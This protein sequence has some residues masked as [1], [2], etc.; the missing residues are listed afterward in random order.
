[1]VNRDSEESV[2]DDLLDRYA[3]CLEQGEPFTGGMFLD[4][5]EDYGYMVIPIE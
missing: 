3:E 4:Y 1:M 5:L 2:I